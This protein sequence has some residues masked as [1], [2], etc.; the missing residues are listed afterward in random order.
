MARKRCRR[1][2]TDRRRLPLYRGCVKYLM[3]R[4]L[5]STVFLLCSLGA[6]SAMAAGNKALEAPARANVPLTRQAYEAAKVAIEKQRDADK[7]A[8]RRLKGDAKDV[9]HAQAEG[10]EKAGKAQLEARWKRTP[11]AVEEARFATADA[12]YKVA[13]EKCAALKDEAED[14][15]ID[16]AKAAREAARRHARVEKVDSTGGIFGEGAAGKPGARVPKS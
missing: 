11:D 8:C 3:H 16:E 15:C 14:R 5:I 9:C 1:V 2:P 10:R 12:N 7:K 6:G 13:R 4:K